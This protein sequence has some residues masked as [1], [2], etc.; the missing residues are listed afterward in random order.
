MSERQPGARRE[1]D[2][3][4]ERERKTEREREDTIPAGWD[5]NGVL[6]GTNVD[7]PS[8]KSERA[9]ARERESGR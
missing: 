6:E 7:E 2:R 4:R 9:R 3:E 5:A 1:E 8:S